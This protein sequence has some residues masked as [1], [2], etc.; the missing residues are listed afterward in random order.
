[1]P[2]CILAEGR[3]RGA[4]HPARGHSP[5]KGD[6]GRTSWHA[7][8]ERRHPLKTD[9]VLWGSGFMFVLYVLL[10]APQLKKYML[11]HGLATEAEI[12]AIEERVM[13]EVE[14]SVK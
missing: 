6:A 11:E 8:A 2:A 1:M 4:R 7:H 10:P 12:K 3:R 13:E 9:M 14:D 5:H